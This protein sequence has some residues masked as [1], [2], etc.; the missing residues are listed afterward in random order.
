LGILADHEYFGDT[1]PLEFQILR[2]RDVVETF[3]R[4]ADRRGILLP[5]L[6]IGKTVAV[7]SEEW[8]TL[9]VLP[10][11]AVAQHY[12][13]PTRLLD[14]TDNPFVAAYFAAK[15]CAQLLKKSSEGPERFA[16]WAFEILNT[17][18][19]LQ[20]DF[21][22]QSISP[23]GVY[24]PNLVA[25]SGRLTIIF[26]EKANISLMRKGLDEILPAKIKNREVL[27]KITAP[28]SEAGR[29]LRLLHEVTID[30]SSMFPG[31]YGAAMM[32]FEDVLQDY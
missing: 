29:T 20:A 11:L 25:Q 1:S 6:R 30:G 12:G 16:V 7:D 24:N 23:P 21:S 2:E 5:E 13:V 26:W 32:P 28:A 19:N 14:W 18:L 3:A 15:E 31:L 27:C 22:V 17:V 4:S 10:L 8:P 9:E